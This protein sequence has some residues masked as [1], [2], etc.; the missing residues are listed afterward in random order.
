MKSFNSYFSDLL[1]QNDRRANASFST[2]LRLWN[3]LCMSQLYEWRKSATSARS[4]TSKYQMWEYG[5]TLCLFHFPRQKISPLRSEQS[6]CKTWLCVRFFTVQFLEKKAGK[7]LLPSKFYPPFCICTLSFVHQ[8]CINR[9][10]PVKHPFLN[11]SLYQSYWLLNCKSINCYCTQYLATL[12]VPCLSSRSPESEFET[13]YAPQNGILTIALWEKEKSWGI[14]LFGR[15]EGTQSEAEA[16]EGV[17]MDC[18]TNP[19]S[20]RLLELL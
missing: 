14:A 8:T 4:N 6:N 19:H 3:Q 17:V 12:G 15:G 1:L 11:I 2:M 10:C 5:S 16:G 13:G 18:R 9:K 7:M 20:S